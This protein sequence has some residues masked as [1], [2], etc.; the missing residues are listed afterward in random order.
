[1]INTREIATGYRL[2]HWAGIIRERAESGLTVKAF[3]ESAGVHP[4]S[5]FY[6]QR[7]LREAA[8]G[9]GTAAGALPAP[10]GWTAAVP[11]VSVTPG[12]SRALP[13]EI[14]KCRVI[15]DTDTDERLLAKVCRVL[16]SL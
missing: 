11:T 15:A 6:W 3:C 9:S 5:Y 12:I 10:N 16:M 2:E 7:R 8:C 13:I 14:G 4:N 1:M